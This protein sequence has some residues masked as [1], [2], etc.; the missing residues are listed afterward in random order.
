MNTQSILR[1]S[2]ANN[3]FQQNGWR[4][5]ILYAPAPACTDSAANGCDVTGQF[6]TLT[7]SFT[8]LSGPSDLNEQVILLG[9]GSL[10]ATQNRTILADKSVLSNYIEGENLT[11]LDFVYSRVFQ[12]TNQ[13]DLATSIP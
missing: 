10:L 5:F 2:Q 7:N 1:G 3:W 6:L 8:P 4:E 11:P 12:N 13:N 9:A